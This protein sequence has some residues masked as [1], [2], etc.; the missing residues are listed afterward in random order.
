MDNGQVIFHHFIYYFF[1]SVLQLQFIGELT[2]MSVELKE[3]KHQYIV[4]LLLFSRS[5]YVSFIL[6]VHKRIE[7]YHS[8]HERP[9]ER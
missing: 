3:N 8:N 6:I 2:D 5:I 9:N 7:M 1:F 4:A